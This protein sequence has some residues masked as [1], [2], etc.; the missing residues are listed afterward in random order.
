MNPW[1]KETVNLQIGDWII[2]K[3]EA[4]AMEGQQADKREVDGR[5]PSRPTK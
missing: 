4:V 3:D 2:W 1:R 5:N